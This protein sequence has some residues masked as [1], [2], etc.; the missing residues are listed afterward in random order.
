MLEDVA[1]AIRRH[2]EGLLA[3]GGQIRL[4]FVLHDGYPNDAAAAKKLCQ[5]LRGKVEVISVLLDPD[6]GTRNAMG[7]IFGQ[8]RLVACGSGELP[9][10]L[11]AMLRSVRGV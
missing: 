3:G 10:K 1:V 9:K 2:S 7:G 11:V 8:D 4:L 6:E 5:E